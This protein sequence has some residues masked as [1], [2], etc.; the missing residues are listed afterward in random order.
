MDS[1]D[2]EVNPSSSKDIKEKFLVSF[3]KLQLKV[4]ALI[5]K[6]KE[7]QDE[8]IAFKEN[9]RELNL[10][11]SEL[12][13]QLNKINSESIQKDKEISDLR[14]LLLDSSNNKI[15]LQDKEKVRSRIK[16]LISRIDVHL[17]QYDEND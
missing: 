2:N 15:S 4:R 13:L 12:K 8:N 3:E 9:I 17:S 10:K 5:L 7:S 6:L 16:D 14:N 1:K 11:L